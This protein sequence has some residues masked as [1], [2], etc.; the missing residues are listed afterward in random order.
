MVDLISQTMDDSEEFDDDPGKVEIYNIANSETRFSGDFKS[1]C[2]LPGHGFS[3]KASCG[4]VKYMACLR[5]H[6]HEG[7]HTI[8][9]STMSCGSKNCNICFPKWQSGAAIKI[10]DRLTSGTLMR[11]NELIRQ[12]TRSRVFIHAVI[13]PPPKVWNDYLVSRKS[14]NIMRK[15]CYK[16]LENCADIDGGVMI[17]HAYRFDKERTS[18]RF[19]PHFHVLMSGWIYTEK[20]KSNYDLGK[21]L[22]DEFEE[23]QEVLNVKR[24]V[25]KNK[26]KPR[27]GTLDSFEMDIE[28]KSITKPSP[29]GTTIVKEISTGDTEK[30]LFNMANYLLSHSTAFIKDETIMRS[31]SEH[32]FRW[33]G[34]YS[35]PKFKVLSESIYQKDQSKLR[36][37]LVD[38]YDLKDDNENNLIKNIRVVKSII[39]DS[40]KNAENILIGECKSID[41]LDILLQK[42][43]FCDYDTCHKDYPACPKSKTITIEPELYKRCDYCDISSLDDAD[44][45]LC[46]QNN[47]EILIYINDNF[48]KTIE[49]DPIEDE[50]LKDCPPVKSY[51]TIQ[52]EYTTVKSKFLVL[53]LSDSIEA[54]CP[55][56]FNQLQMVI[57]DHPDKEI[58]KSAL[59]NFVMDITVSVGEDPH[60]VPWVDIMDTMPGI[61]YYDKDNEIQYD[62]GMYNETE[63]YG[64]LNDTIKEIIKNNIKFYRVKGRC[65]IDELPCRKAD[66][67]EMMGNIKINKD[68]EIQYNSDRSAGLVQL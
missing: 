45:E 29:Y 36:K 53:A 6:N 52:F 33:F 12:D 65:K 2:L 54:L 41:E 31:S 50:I 26:Q 57:Y 62:L 9:K 32:S 8:K 18:A 63:N 22:I 55:L 46:K 58:V 48:G 5:T 28:I 4:A 14:R 21:K 61:P 49:L 3:G 59:A 10:S 56:C 34:D 60:W 7:Q 42:D 39:K 11:N 15:Q 1:T 40:V 51:I 16:A 13:S 19:S 67:L 47:H 68:L 44:F 66:I 30:Q 37:L 38:K 20:V 17:D 64:K 43:V 24:K 23:G 25:F 35:Y 27:K